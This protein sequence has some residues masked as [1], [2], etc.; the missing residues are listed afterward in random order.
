MRTNTD[1]TRDFTG[2]NNEEKKTHGRSAVQRT[3][4]GDPW[5]YYRHEKEKSKGIEEGGAKNEKNGLLS[6]SSDII[7]SN[8]LSRIIIIFQAMYHQLTPINNEQDRNQ[9]HQY[10]N[11]Y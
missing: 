7:N 10:H 3:T 8:P 5:R 1:H 4:S 9:N 11:Q 2:K 6:P